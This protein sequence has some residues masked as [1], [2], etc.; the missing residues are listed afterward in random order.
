MALLDFYRELRLELQLW[1]GSGSR[2]GRFR[3]QFLLL[4]LLFKFCCNAVTAQ[5]RFH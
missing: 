1:L 2:E 3:Y 5:V 4:K